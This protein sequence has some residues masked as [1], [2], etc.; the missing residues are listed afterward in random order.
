MA[1][2]TITGD[3][4]REGVGRKDNRPWYAWAADYQ[5][6]NP[7]VITPRR[8][9]PLIPSNGVLTFEIEAGISAW[10]ENPDGQRY[11]V[12]IPVVDS[13]LWEVI[14]AGVAIP[15]DTPTDQ[16]AAMFTN[17]LESN[18][19]AETVENYVDTKVPGM[20][21]EAVAADASVIAAAATAAE[22]AVDDYVSGELDLIQGTVAADEDDDTIVGIRDKKKR[23][24]FRVGA[25]GVTEIALPNLA[26]QQLRSGESPHGYLPGFAKDSAGRTAENVY[27][28]DGTKPRWVLQR[29][30]DRMGW[31]VAPTYRDW[32]IV[33]AGQSNMAGSDPT[34]APT[35][36]YDTDPRLVRYDRASDAIV[37]VAASSGALWATLGRAVLEKVPTDVR[38]V[39]IHAAAGST[40][41][42]RTS[43]SP[44]PDAGPYGAY[45]FEENGT[46]DR[47]LTTDPLNRYL[48][49]VDDVASA[50]ALLPDAEVHAMFWSQGE[51]DT[52]LRNQTSYSAL[53]D[54][55][56]TTFRTEVGDSALPVVVGSLVPEWVGVDANRL[57]IQTALA[58]TPRRLE[59]TAFVYGPENV[60]PDGSG[61]NIHFHTSGALRRA[62][63]MA[64]ALYR[65]RW[66]A[67]GQQALPVQNLTLTRSGTQLTARWDSPLTQHTLITPEFTVN[68]GSSWAAM[69]KQLGDIGLS[70]TA[71]IAASDVVQ[72]RVSTTN[73]DGT[74]PY[75]YA[76]A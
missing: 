20:V 69:T 25:N 72:V 37:P 15:P 35:G 41:F 64:A 19:I 3:T 40:G 58:D 65:A 1:L 42:S 32:I 62:R 51:S 73:G 24:A 22:T 48:M 49:M 13:P 7:G 56:I 27:Y 34:T 36:A 63:L 53:L 55:L 30:A 66:N 31:A 11:L 74:S 33:C 61:A 57:G 9:K 23:K 44:L 68:G 16:L 10:I 38:V 4:I 29:W 54:D 76:S 50:R 8:S 14:E 46:W 52:T 75:I 43:L 45:V 59:K 71:T 26:G 39:V 2:V 70:A 28:T 17:Y 67:A 60:G 5:D 21:A 12:T 18:P 47:T 6:G